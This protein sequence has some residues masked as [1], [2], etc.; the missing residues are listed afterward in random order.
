M[1]SDSFAI[2]V[3]RQNEPLALRQTQSQLSVFEDVVNVQ[4]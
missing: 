1:I 4:L 2:N 3:P